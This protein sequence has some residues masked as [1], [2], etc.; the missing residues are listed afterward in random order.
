[1]ARLVNSALSK[2]S[3]RNS[4]LAELGPVRACIRQRVLGNF[5]SN[6]NGFIINFYLYL[7]EKQSNSFAKA[8]I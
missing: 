1:M 8:D 2:L 5:G 3:A 4:F 6:R 7:T